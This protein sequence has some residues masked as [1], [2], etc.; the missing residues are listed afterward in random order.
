MTAPLVSIT[1]AGAPRGKGRPRFGNGHTFTPAAT[2]SYE[3]ALRFAAQQA[4]GSRTPLV[5]P[6][7]LVMEARMPVPA[8]WSRTKKEAALAGKYPATNKPDCDNILKSI[9]SL[10]QIVFVDDKQIVRATVNK[11]YSAHP[12]LTIDV[13]SWEAAT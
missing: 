2:R 9:D 10:N 11:R 12:G 7:T 8:S 13:H 1:L 3:A 4:M 5:G 6:L